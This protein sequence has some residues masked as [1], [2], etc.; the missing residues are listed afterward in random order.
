MITHN[1]EIIVTDP[2]KGFNEYKRWGVFPSS[3]THVRKILLHV[4]FACPDSLRCADWDYLDIISIKKIGGV[5]GENKDFEIARMLTP[6]GGAFAKDW[7]FDWELEVTDFSLLLRDSVEIEYN[8][9]GYENNKDRGWLVTLDFEI[10]KGKPVAEPLSI[11]KIYSGAFKYGDSSTPIENFLKPVNFPREQDASFAK[12]RVYQ[13]SHGDN[14]A[15]ECGEFC[16]KKR[17]IVFNGDVIDTRPIW[18]KCGDN[19]LYPQA[20]T[21]I[22][23]RANWC[24][25]YLQIPDEYLL[26]L[27]ENNTIDINMEPYETPK[28]EAVENI[29]AY[30]IQYKKT[31]TKNDISVAGMT[32]PSNKKANLRI[33]PAC[34][35]AKIVLKNNGRNELKQV[36][37]AYR[38]I[39]FP[40]KR[41]LWKG[42][43]PFNHQTEIELPGTID[44]NK[45]GNTFLVNLSMP[46]GKTDE[47]AI[48]NSMASHFEK[49]AVHAKNLVLV[50]KT[51]NQP[52]HNY[53]SIT[54]SEGVVAY[55][56]RFDSTQKNKLFRDS[57][58]LAEGCY[59]LQIKDTAGDGLEFWFNTKGGRGY[60]RL[61]DDKGNLLKNFES[62]FGSAI[63]YNFMVS[64][65]VEQLSE[66]N[67][68]PAIGLY[69][70]RTNGKTIMDYFSGTPQDVTV[71]II[72]DEGAKLVEEHQ[73]KNLK[74]GIFT[75]DLAYRPAQRYYLKVFINGELKFNK[76]IRVVDEPLQ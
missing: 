66:V 54:N 60:A 2:A 4:K 33:N 69:P 3:K 42:R 67:S 1:R 38:T 55:Q 31:E 15:D 27:K 19:P 28:S 9:T 74:E 16:S 47:S 39:G 21:W 68:E 72:T 6:Y 46:N 51:N 12:F 75:Y 50:F 73:Y 41:Y 32:I 14:E 25:G 52:Q 57:L 29:T 22:L 61:Q 37:I 23:D 62:D 36:W 76:R 7:K 65:D 70:T 59:Q 49:A 8:H 35:K 53:Y 34:A 17:E 11:Q 63:T 45:G 58:H 44:A 5:S 56:R 30:I 26:P 64:D 13:T 10:I 24:P 43:L 40:E 18:K 48:D 71:Q 20:G